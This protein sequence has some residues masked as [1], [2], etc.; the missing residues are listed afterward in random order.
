MDRSVMTTPEPAVVSLAAIGDD[1]LGD[2]TAAL[3]NEPRY[4]GRES[5]PRPSHRWASML[6]HPS[7]PMGVGAVIDTELVG[8]A[9]LCADEE[10]HLALYVA[11]APR[12][13]RLGIATR[14]VEEVLSVAGSVGDGTVVAVSEHHKAPVR[15]LQHRFHAQA[16]PSP[17]SSAPSTQVRFLVPSP[18]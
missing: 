3:Q 6:A 9:R 8:V 15:S 2:F 13:R 17:A 4:F 18:S 7:R 12:W 10:E 14:L 1:T 11:V 16:T 5:M